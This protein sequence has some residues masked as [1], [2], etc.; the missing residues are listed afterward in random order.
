MRMSDWISG[1]CSSDLEFTGMENIRAAL[2]YNGLTDDAVEEVVADIVDFCEL[3]DFIDQPVKTYSL[4]MR[5][6][7]QFAAATAIKPDIVIID[8][9]LGAGD[10][11]FAGKSVERIKRLTHDDATLLIVS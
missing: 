4:G 9:V 2:V 6:R 5:A 8:E 11:Y 3:G 10:A 1:V 7:L